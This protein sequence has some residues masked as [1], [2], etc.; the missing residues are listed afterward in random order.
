M[1]HTDTQAP[2]TRPHGQSMAATYLEF[3]ID[4]EIERLHGETAWASSGQN[5]RTLVKYDDFRVVLAVLRAGGRIPEHRT[6]GRISIQTLRGHL[7]VK[8]EGRTFN[9][10]AGSLL[11]LDRT[12]PHDVDARADSAFLLT[13]AWPQR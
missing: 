10:P 11:T 13:I 6:E 9:L 3:D 5:A 12:V 1:E 4:A 8:A 7:Q 2:H